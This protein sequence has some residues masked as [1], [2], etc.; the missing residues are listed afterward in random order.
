MPADSKN[1]I[2]HISL[3]SR[4]S[5]SW[6]WESRSSRNDLPQM[7]SGSFNLRPMGEAAPRPEISQAILTTLA[8]SSIS[9]TQFYY[10]LIRVSPALLPLPFPFPLSIPAPAFSVCSPIFLFVGDGS[11]RY[12]IP[13][14]LSL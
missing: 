3:L 10:N 13:L 1:I 4:S 9:E 6:T 14:F 8:L 7:R 12:S 5:S 11:P 2:V